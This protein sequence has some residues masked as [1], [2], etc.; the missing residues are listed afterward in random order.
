MVQRR[1]V[2]LAGTALVA[3]SST[4]PDAAQ[5]AAKRREIDGQVDGAV[6][7]LLTNAPGARQIAANSEGYLVFPEV[8]TAGLLI[9]GSH[10][11]GS[12]RKGSSTLGY[13]SVSSG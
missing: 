13:Y 9:G 11:D 12:L 7:E 6:G 8:F 4:T 3:G 5:A 10:G 1:L 2:L